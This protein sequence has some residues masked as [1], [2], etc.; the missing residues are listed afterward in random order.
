MFYNTGGV[1]VVAVC[2]IRLNDRRNFKL[3][4]E[5]LPFGNIGVAW[6]NPLA[7]GDSGTFHGLSSNSWLLDA[8]IDALA[9]KSGL[10]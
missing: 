3:Q 2:G 10:G 7:D 8:I 6:S 4:I 9:T 5:A 1:S